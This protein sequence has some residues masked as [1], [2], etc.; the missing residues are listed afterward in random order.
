MN[1]KDRHIINTSWLFVQKISV[2]DKLSNTLF[3][4]QEHYKLI[5][6]AEAMS[7]VLPSFLDL[8]ERESEKCIAY[9]QSK[10]IHRYICV[11]HSQCMD[12]HF[13]GGS[14]ILFAE[15]FSL[16]TNAF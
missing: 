10:G 16:G 8:S 15:I 6:K 4:S 13:A 1:R 12:G 11:A 2:V 5:I 9:D 3:L 14:D 7:I